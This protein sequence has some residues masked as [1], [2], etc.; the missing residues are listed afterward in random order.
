VATLI[1]TALVNAGLGAQ[2]AAG[3]ANLAMSFALSAVSALLQ[4]GAQGPGID[5][6]REL[7]VPNSLPPYRFAYGASGTA[8]IPGSWAPGWVVSNGVLYGCLI[9]NSRPSA[10]GDVRVYIDKR[11]ITL[12]GDIF[13]FDEGAEATNAPFA[14]HFKCWFGRGDQS[15]PP[16]QIMS[17]Y[18]DPAGEDAGKFWPTDR[19]T[20]RTVLWVRCVAGAAQSRQERWPT[21]PPLIEVEADWSLIHDIRDP[22]Q[23]A[24]DPATWGVSNNQVLCLIDAARF[25]PL[26]RWP[27]RLLWLDQLRAAAD[28]ADEPVPIKGGGTE[29]RY[30]VGGLLVFDGESELLDQLQPLAEAGAGWIVR[31]GGML[32]YA[33]GVWEEPVMTLTQH[34]RDGP[35]VFRASRARRE[36]PAAVKASFPD[37]DQAW[38]KGE[39]EP[40]PVL[41]D[42]DGSDDR[43]RTVDLTLVPFAR[44]A[45][46]VQQIMARRLAQE[47]RLSAVWPPAA[48]KAVAGATV[49][50]AMPRETDPRSGTYRV[51]QMHP[52]RFLEQDGGVALAMPMD[53]E[54]DAPE[55]YAWVPET[56]EQD[57]P[58]P[59]V[60]TL[61]LSLPTPRFVE[62]EDDEAGGIALVIGVPGTTLVVRAEP[63]D[64]GTAVFT[65]SSLVDTVEWQWRL[66]DGP[67]TE[68][69]RIST[70]LS[71]GSAPADDPDAVAELGR[72]TALLPG[73]A[74]GT[75]TIRARS[76]SAGRTSAFV[77]AAPVVIPEP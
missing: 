13:D 51:A 12:T 40:V 29:P 44:Q 32:G 64:P 61:D 56:D 60:A 62:A 30:R 3:I 65:P 36:L 28:V 63:G 43:I 7:P 14:G 27:L 4:Q 71:A 42:W 55:V 37:P 19:W 2:L 1:A 16:E 47:R 6:S 25:N 11:P 46:R 53:L 8:R 73:V 9:L 21:S 69:G 41:D 15:G 18:G 39:L 49:A 72:V 34:L 31:A 76:V 17:E 22:D 10:G 59:L 33:P 38:E 35:M 66:G 70:D 26:A 57:R 77:T 75:Y 54:G 23:D 20:G 52:A 74:P 24:D 68:G 48:I 5:P 45:M 58:D 50:V 67:W